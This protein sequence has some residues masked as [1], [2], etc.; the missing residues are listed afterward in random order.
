M[1]TAWAARRGNR[2]Q[3][4]SPRSTAIA[5][6]ALCTLL[7]LTFLDNTVV[8]VG[9]GS[10]QTDLSASVAD[11]QWIV[12]GVRA[13]VRQHHA[14]LRHDRRRAGP[15]VGHAG[16][17]RGLLRGLHRLR[18]RAQPAAAHR[19]PGDHGPRRGRERAGDAVGAAAPLHRRAGPARAIG[20][21]AAVS[22]PG[23]GARPGGRRHPGRRVELARDLLVQPGV[24]TGGA[25]HRGAGRPGELRP[26]QRT[27]WTPSARCSA[28]RRSA[29]WCRRSSTPRRTG[30]PTRSS[31]RCCAWPRS[32]PGRSSGGSGGPR[33]RCST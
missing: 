22:G 5:L 16:R 12:G 29:R 33:S 8:S 6:A 24:R 26:A 25:D 2:D 30:S 32:P 28:P 14:G 20:I 13:D 1:T 21:W 15:Q 7:F 4:A 27:G 10:I 19:R 11:L 9:L 3:T 23:P 17:R 18:R 31:S